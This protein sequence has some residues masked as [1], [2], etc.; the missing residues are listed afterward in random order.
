M[1]YSY[2][3][4]RSAKPTVVGRELLSTAVHVRRAKRAAHYWRQRFGLLLVIL[5]LLVGIINVL[6]LDTDPVV[7]PATT[8][9]VGFLHPLTTY[10]HTA[11]QL[12]ARSVLNRNKITVDT[13]GVAAGLK[14]AYPE[15][16]LATITLPLFGHHPYIYIAQAD[17]A[18]VLATQSG[19]HYI[20]DTQGRA[21]AAGDGSTRLS[22][23]LLKVTDQSG[24]TIT[25][26]SLAVPSTTVAFI[27][28]I[29]FQLAQR[30]V[31]VDHFSLP[32]AGSELDVYL[33][34]VRYFIKFN[35]ASGTALQ[36]AGTFLATQQYFEGRG[37][38]PG[39]YVD[40]RLDGRAYYR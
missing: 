14:K 40:V 25:T 20:I 7:K 23:E 28:T 32:A 11:E 16:S 26:G 2:H 3:A 8:A 18:L 37:I 17:P 4:Q 30:Q 31:H 33:T 24:A 29:H 39:Q 6:A 21:I 27:K 22:L 15:L 13:S 19:Q 36:Q 1:P 34:G 5:A 10:Q 12:L 38:N 9:A 35:L